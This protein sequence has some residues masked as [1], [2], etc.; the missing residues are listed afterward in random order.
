[1][2][3]LHI[4]QVTIYSKIFNEITDKFNMTTQNMCL[5][6]LLYVGY[7]FIDTDYIQKYIQNIIYSS[8]ESSITIS[9][10]KQTFYSYSYGLK[11]TIKNIHS[12]RFDAIT[13]FLIKHN[14]KQVS[15]ITEI[16]NSITS[17]DNDSDSQITNEFIYLPIQYQKILICEKKQIYLEIIVDDIKRNDNANNSNANNNNN[18]PSDKKFNKHYTYKLSTYGIGRA[19]IVKDFIDSRIEEY[20][21][22]NDTNKT[23]IYEYIKSDKD[24]DVCKPVYKEY[25]F[26]SNKHLDKNIFFDGREE[27][28]KYIDQFSKY[29]TPEEQQ[30]CESVY[31]KNGITFK[32]GILLYGETG[33]GKTSTVRGILNRTGRIGVIIRWSLL[34]TCS[35]FRAAFSNKLNKKTY[36]LKD[37]CFIIEDFDANQDDVIKS[38]KDFLPTSE[39]DD[40][41]NVYENVSIINED[42]NEVVKLKKQ[43]E[44]MK[45]NTQLA[46]QNADKL[47]LDFILNFFDGIIEHHGSMVIFTTNHIEKIDTAFLRPGRIDYKIFFDKA[48]VRN[49]REMI[50]NK[51]KDDGI[52]FNTYSHYFEN[53]KDRVISYADVQQIYLRYDSNNIEK[54]LVQLVD[55]TNV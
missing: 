28:I 7:N 26:N 35:E 25:N 9:Q 48:N 34:K 32:A 3:P 22:D 8:N 27:F 20:E 46:T 55:A 39:S 36:A 52:D 6:V 4:L 54:C 12:I 45:I 51:Y 40:F 42:Q 47:T 11:E 38:R 24:D 23:P 44:I 18:E 53:M 33:C 16:I 10:H 1:M 5:C 15:N 49:I 19:Q 13:H 17:N 41:T 21:K 14:I 30:K 29:I 31:E 43:I 37:L 50:E 2:N